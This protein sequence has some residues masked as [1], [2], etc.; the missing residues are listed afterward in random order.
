MCTNVH[1][2]VRLSVEVVNMETIEYKH[3]QGNGCS[4]FVP[5]TMATVHPIYQ[6]SFTLA[7]MRH[8]A[9]IRLHIQMI[10]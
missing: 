2:N 3:H 6:P 10:I 7:T 9:T 8:Q 4:V 5:V 1:S